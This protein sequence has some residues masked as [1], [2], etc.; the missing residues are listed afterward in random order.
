[1]K[2]HPL[3]PS[4]GCLYASSYILHL[5]NA[6]ISCRICIFS[7]KL[8]FLSVMYQVHH[9]CYCHDEG[10]IQNH[11]YHS[12]Y[13]LSTYSGFLRGMGC[14]SCNSFAISEAN[15]ASWW[16]PSCFLCTG[17]QISYWSGGS[18]KLVCLHSV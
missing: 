17:S 9:H 3:M 11:K 2:H 7:P 14:K 4:S 5:C 6:V 18:V 13:L 15:I 16:L 8:T 10:A 1:M 12:I